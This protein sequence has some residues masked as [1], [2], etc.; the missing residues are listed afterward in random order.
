MSIKSR[1]MVTRL[2]TGRLRAKNKWDVY[3]ILENTEAPG[4][5]RFLGLST[6]HEHHARFNDREEAIG[7]AVNLAKQDEPIFADR[8]HGGQVKIDRQRFIQQ[9]RM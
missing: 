7:Y 6:T 9:E 4:W 1:I 3:R 5:R 8:Q 2:P